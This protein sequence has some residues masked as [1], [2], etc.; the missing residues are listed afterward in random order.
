MQPKEA[1]P[2]CAKFH[3]CGQLNT[4]AAGLI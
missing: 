1:I 3:V 4:L 2:S